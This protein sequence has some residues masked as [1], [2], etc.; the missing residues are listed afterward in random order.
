MGVHKS[1]PHDC[2]NTHL[3]NGAAKQRYYIIGRVDGKDAKSW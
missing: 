2:K 1:S 3:A